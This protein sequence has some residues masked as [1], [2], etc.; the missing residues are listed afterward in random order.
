MI[1]G[2]CLASP[3]FFQKG[4]YCCNMTSFF[5][6]KDVIY[7]HMDFADHIC[8]RRRLHVQ[9]FF[10]FFLLCEFYVI[11]CSHCIIIERHLASLR[12]MVAIWENAIIKKNIV[13]FA[14]FPVTRLLRPPL[15]KIPYPRLREKIGFLIS[16]VFLRGFLRGK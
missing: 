2:G 5:F 16:I 3:P 12:Q 6:K 9:P 1:I 7:S 8:S 15:E 11:F 14:I 4:G 10:T 13:D